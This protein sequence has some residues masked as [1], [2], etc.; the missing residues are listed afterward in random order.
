MVTANDLFV[1]VT[2]LLKRVT[3]INADPPSCSG[4]FCFLEDE[5]PHSV[6][7]SAATRLATQIVRSSTLFLFSQ[8]YHTVAAKKRSV[9]FLFQQMT[10]RKQ[11]IITNLLFLSTELLVPKQV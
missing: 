11:F 4:R 6:S 9:S 10:S 1:L 3:G 7:S 2:A 8:Q 5:S